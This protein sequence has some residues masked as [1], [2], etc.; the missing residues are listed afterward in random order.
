[1]ADGLLIDAY[2]IVSAGHLVF[3]VHFKNRSKPLRLKRN[4]AIR[5]KM[6][7]VDGT[8][9]LIQFSM[10]NV[11]IDSTFRFYRA[12]EIRPKIQLPDVSYG[13]GGQAPYCAV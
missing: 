2:R 11:P 13:S 8:V 10:M 1:M 5:L 3:L 4:E 9:I 7:I 6:K 12:F